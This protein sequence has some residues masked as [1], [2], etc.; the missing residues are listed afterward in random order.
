MTLRTSTS[1]STRTI[2][3]ACAA[4]ALAW[5]A[6]QPAQAR[7]TFHD[8]AVGEK[9]TAPAGGTRAQTCADR[10]HATAGYG[11][12]IDVANG[13]DP[14]AFQVPAQARD[15]I[16]YRVWKAPPGFRS[17][18]GAVEDSGGVYFEDPA[19]P[20]IHHQA[21]LVGR[22]TT[23]PRALL[24]TPEPSGGNPHVSDNFVFAAAP[25][26]V[27]LTGVAPGNALGL[28]PTPQSGGIFVDVT[29]IDCGL[30]VVK[31]RVDV[32]PGSR[33]NRVHPTNAA[34]RIP[35]RIFGTR[36]LNVRRITSV[37][38]GE[39]APASVRRP[40][41]ANRDGRADRVYYFRQGE[42]DMMC[43]DTSVKVTG[44][45]SNHKRFQGRSAIRTAG[46]A[47]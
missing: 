40:K 29:A 26:S 23:P 39:A 9:I 15:A 22:V 17:F 36:R 5:A 45:T 20:T 38:L 8:D 16:S 42:T 3:T 44:S 4:L 24:R 21:T 34:E 41:D 28:G 13:E 31:A 11:H 27:R 43:I 32:L 33:R 46:C 1:T 12:F 35:V 37:H 18:A 7:W 14:A 19:D 25:I 6:A 30:P 2:A 10:L 47:G